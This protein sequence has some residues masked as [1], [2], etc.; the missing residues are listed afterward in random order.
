MRPIDYEQL[1]ADLDGYHATGG[2][3]LVEHTWCQPSAAYASPERLA[4]ELAGVFDRVPL[5]AAWSSEL[6]AP[7][8]YVARTV[9][10][11]PLL[12]VRQVDGSLRAFLNACRHRSVEVVA[13]E[14]AG[15]ARRFTCPYHG[16]TYDDAGALVGLP[17]RDAFD[18]LDPS[19]LGLV[20]LPCAER[21]GLVL[22]GR[23]PGA[24]LDAGAFLG[25]LD[26]E[27][28]AIGLGGFVA[29]RRM[30]FEVGANWKLIVDGF[31]ETYHVRYL[32][33]ASLRDI[34][35]SDRSSYHRFGAHG[36]LAVLR[37]TYDPAT[38]GGPED[39][40]AQVSMS[41]RL[42]PNTTITWFSDHFELW[43]I[44][45][46]LA[47]P[48]RTGVHMTLLVRPEERAD[49]RKWDRNATISTSVITSEDFVAAAST[50]RTLDGGAAPASFVYGRNEPGVQHFHQELLASI[51]RTERTERSVL[52]VSP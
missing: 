18:D 19:Q 29:E 13:G 5:V 16:W 38:H 50:Q 46:D 1:K 47:T 52:V 4:D 9:V 44:E 45:P 33:G 20:A 8:T 41:Y 31:L 21:H 37:K 23:R 17:G 40:L 25:R 49:T 2:R 15:C 10:G 36:R 24:A 14:A 27:L 30:S 39:L 3:A 28:E 34:V 26:A 11:T 35:H 48:G 32:H 6:P 51:E 22:V 42:F 43:Q 12:L 7:G